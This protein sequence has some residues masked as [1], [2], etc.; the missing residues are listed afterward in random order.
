VK[1]KYRTPIDAL[2]HAIHCAFV[3][4]N[5]RRKPGVVIERMRGEDR[6]LLRELTSEQALSMRPVM[7]GMEPRT[8]W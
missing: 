7:L 4:S 5:D 6:E 3:S 2:E 8:R 1:S